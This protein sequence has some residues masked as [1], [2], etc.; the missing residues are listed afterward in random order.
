M[1]E[2]LKGLTRQRLKWLIAI[3][4]EFQ[5]RETLPKWVGELK[6]RISEEKEKDSVI[7]RQKYVCPI[8]KSELIDAGKGDRECPCCTKSFNLNDPPN[9]Y[10]IR[11][12][13]YLSEEKEASNR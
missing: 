10:R 11:C 9:A 3:A 4:E 12:E 8:C 2:E 7:E 1:T 13:E 6:K 5:P